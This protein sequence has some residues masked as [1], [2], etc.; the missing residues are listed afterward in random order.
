MNLFFLWFFTLGLFTNL[1]ST[2][3]TGRTP[4]GLP[5]Y[6]YQDKKFS[7]FGGTLSLKLVERIIGADLQVVQHPNTFKGIKLLGIDSTLVMSR[8]N[9]VLWGTGMNGKRMDPKSYQF[10]NLDI[11]SVRG[12]LTREF[13]RKNFSIDCPKIY[14]DP[15]LLFPFL[16]P[17]YKKKKKPKNAYIIIPHYSEIHRFPKKLYPN[18]VYPTENWKHIIKKILNSEFVISGALHG[19]VIAE[20][21]G[22]PARYIRT[23]DS[24]PL[25]KYEDY[26]LGTGRSGANY[27]TTVEEAL[28]M[29]GEEPYECNLRD[30]YDSFPFEYYPNGNFNPPPFS[31]WFVLDL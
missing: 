12:P 31:R 6:Y 4:E 18:A 23:N 30:L 22:I 27:A 1:Y 20:A 14:G 28:R 5:F 15:A 8:N 26:Y 21:Y 16:F 17:E 19:I 10:S 29:G 2:E 13:I 24:E 9:D 3:P 7:N 11:R 25:F